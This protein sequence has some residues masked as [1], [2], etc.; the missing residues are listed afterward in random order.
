MLP[1]AARPFLAE[2]PQPRGQLGG[3]AEADAHRL[4]VQQRGA[5]A[6]LRFEGMAEGVAEVEQGAAAIGLR[7]E[8]VL[9]DDGGFQAAA[10]DH[11]VGQRRGVALHGH[12]ALALAPLPQR[13]VQQPVLRHLR[14]ARAELARRQRGERR[15]VGEHEPGLVERA[16]QVLAV[17]RVDA[18]L[19]ADAAV[20]LGQQGG[21]ALHEVQAAQHAGRA[22]PR[23][24]A[25]DAAAERHDDGAAV[26]ARGQHRL[27]HARVL[28]PR[29]RCLAGGHEDLRGELQARIGQA[30]AQ[31]GQVQGCDRGVADDEHAPARADA[32]DLS[33]R[34]A[35]QPIADQDRVAAARERD[36]EPLRRAV[37]EH[38]VGDAARGD[39]GGLVGA[40]HVQFGLGVGGVARGGQLLQHL[41]RVAAGEHRPVLAA[42]DAAQQR[43]HP[44][45]EPDRERAGGM[46]GA[47]RAALR[48]GAAARRQHH[49]RAGEDARDHAP[50]QLAELRLAVAGEKLGDGKPGRLLDFG[51]RVHEGQAKPQREPPPNGRLP[52]ARHADE[53]DGARECGRVR[54]G[55]RLVGEVA[56]HWRRS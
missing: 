29:L 9:R 17:R 13:A 40:G 39:L 44:A 21:R 15:R 42:R 35:K 24:V 47:A 41:P 7:L 30:F 18:G 11:G 19:A 28:L 6:A 49:G 26:G 5:V 48:E 37:G 56:R 55:F 36:R 32:C 16:D 25:H 4:A 52:R 50:L 20:H 38:G 45:F 23:E 46:D 1:H 51:I 31:R 3:E 54:F 27:A 10:L 2:Q 34:A 8:L 12:R 14:P 43:G 53:R 22:E 33:A